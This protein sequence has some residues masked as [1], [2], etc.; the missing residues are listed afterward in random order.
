MGLEE[1]ISISGN[2]VP[3]FY[4]VWLICYG[5]YCRSHGFPFDTRVIVTVPFRLQVDGWVTLAIRVQSIL[6]DAS[7]LEKQVIQ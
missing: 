2:D 3:L 5:F 7:E 6:I 1:F 4:V